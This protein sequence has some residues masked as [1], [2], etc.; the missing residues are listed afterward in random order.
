[1]QVLSDLW[2][3][4]ELVKLIEEGKG[5]S[6]ML[7]LNLVFV[8]AFIQCIVGGKAQ[9][10]FPFPMQVTFKDSES[11]GIYCEIVS[12]IRI[13]IVSHMKDKN[14]YPT[15]ISIHG[16]GGIMRFVDNVA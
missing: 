6:F 3:M 5:F 15:P 2:E 14:L 11:V 7:V 9:T 13:I 10:F 8:N 4:V 1:M 16:E 12:Y